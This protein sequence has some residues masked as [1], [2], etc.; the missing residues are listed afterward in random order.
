M[1]MQ[2]GLFLLNLLCCFVYSIS[3]QHVTTTTI[4]AT[5]IETIEIPQLLSLSLSCQDRRGELENQTECGCNAGC[6]AFDFCCDDFQVSCPYEYAVTSCNNKCGKHRVTIPCK[7]SF[8]KRRFLRE[9]W[10]FSC[11]NALF[12][13]T[14]F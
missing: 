11:E 1:T 6:I 12:M 4:M 10:S 3:I 13:K 14:Y 8:E 9:K 2:R 5:T 7:W